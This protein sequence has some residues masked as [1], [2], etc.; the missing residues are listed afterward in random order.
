MARFLIQWQS[1]RDDRE[2]RVSTICYSKDEMRRR[3]GSPQVRI[4]KPIRLFANFGRKVVATIRMLDAQVLGMAIQDVNF[5]CGRS[6]PHRRRR[7]SARH[8]AR[9]QR[10]AL[11]GDVR[12]GQGVERHDHVSCG[13]R[14][15]GEPAV[16]RCC[17][18]PLTA[19]VLRPRL[20]NASR[21]FGPRLNQGPLLA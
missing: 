8:R 16:S 5:G 15:E 9:R 6:D 13:R 3:H 20:G 4:Q 2:E 12:V 19:H 17:S 10:A 21:H 1:G 18:F 11:A 7:G 14:S